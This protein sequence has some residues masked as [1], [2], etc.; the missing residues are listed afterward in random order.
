MYLLSQK[1]IIKLDNQNGIISFKADCFENPDGWFF[2]EEEA[3]QVKEE[4]ETYATIQNITEIE[5]AEWWAI[6]YLY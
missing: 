5:A 1:Y 2:K 4:I 3:D 6:H